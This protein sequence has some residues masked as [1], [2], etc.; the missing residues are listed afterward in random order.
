MLQTLGLQSRAKDIS[1]CHLSDRRDG[2]LRYPEQCLAAPKKSIK[3][4]FA[5]L[6]LL[7]T[8]LVFAA[9]LLKA[10]AWLTIWSRRKAAC[11]WRCAASAKRAPISSAKQTSRK[12][13][14]SFRRPEQQSARS[15]Q[16]TPEPRGPILLRFH[17]PPL[18]ATK[19]WPIVSAGQASCMRIRHGG[20]A[21]TGHSSFHRRGGLP[22]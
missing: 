9:A 2:R 11:T 14:S 19:A 3:S 16:T 18:I 7:T 20:R 8:T 12:A 22:R 21:Q 6:H 1:L 15:A 4:G 13:A 17:L 5:A 10:I